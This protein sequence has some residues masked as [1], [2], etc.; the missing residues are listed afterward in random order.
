MVR[1]EI[2]RLEADVF[3]AIRSS[4]LLSLLHGGSPAP[5]DSHNF[6]HNNH[7]ANGYNHKNHQ[8]NYYYRDNQTIGSFRRQP[9][10][11][12]LSEIPESI[13]EDRVRPI[14]AVL[15]SI[16]AQ[17]LLDLEVYSSSREGTP[18]W[19]PRVRDG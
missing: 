11:K 14:R 9:R 12:D 2:S 3:R 5:H 8:H 13:L 15:E 18:V 10:Y 4:D 7:H 17:R 16:D 19:G 1:E 6:G